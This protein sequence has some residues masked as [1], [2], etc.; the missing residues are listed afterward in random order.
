MPG[1]IVESRA[2]RHILALSGGKDS[3]ALAVYM[4]EKHPEID[5]EYVFTDSGCELPETYEF[6]DRIRAVLNIDITVIKSEQDFD[7]WLKIFKG[8]LPSPNNRWCTRQLKLKPFEE[9]IGNDFTYS[10]IAIRA[11]E[12]RGGYKNT[13]G[14]INPMYP[15]VSDGIVLDDVIEILDRSGL[16]LPGYY[17]WRSRSGCFFCFYQT[18]DEWGGLKKHHPELFKIAC[19]YEE[20]HSD[21]RI[22]TWRG[23]RG[24]KPLYIRDLDGSLIGNVESKE[25]SKNDNKLIHTIDIENLFDEGGVIL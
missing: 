8:V 14:N 6:L 11:D 5:L 17:K 25:K 10:Y 9:Y 22:Y 7:Y 1:K 19:Q 16:G 20:N 2:V 13:K 24:G 18:L 23:K 4:R 15:F 21:N 3:A 12:D